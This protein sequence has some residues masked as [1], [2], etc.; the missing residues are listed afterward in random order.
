MDSTES[1][2]TVAVEL[3]PDAE[4]SAPSNLSALSDLNETET[5]ANDDSPGSDQDQAENDKTNDDSLGPGEEATSDSAD[6][7]QTSEVPVTEEDADEQTAEESEAV[8]QDVSE[9]EEA[10]ESSAVTEGCA[11]VS[12][13]SGTLPQAVEPP[14]EEVTGAEAGSSVAPKRQRKATAKVLEMEEVKMHPVVTPGP[15]KRGRKP[16][17]K[18]VPKTPE[19]AK[20]AEQSASPVVDSPATPRTKTRELPNGWSMKAVQRLTGASAGKYDIYYFSPENVKCRSRTDVTNYAV[21]YKADLDMELFEFSMSKLQQKGLVDTD[22]VVLARKKSSSVPQKAEKAQA[23]KVKPESGVKKAKGRLNNKSLFKNAKL[24]I[25]EGE[26]HVQAKSKGLFSKKK[27]VEVEDSPQKLQKLVIRMPFGSS[28]KG[29]MTKKESS[30]ICSY[31]APDEMAAEAE[32]VT[33]EIPMEDEQFTKLVGKA[34][35]R[36]GTSPIKGVPVKGQPGKKKKM[37]RPKKNANDSTENISQDTTANTSLLGSSLD[38]SAMDTTAD[39]SVVDPFAFPDDDDDVPEPSSM[40]MS[41]I[42][43]S[44]PVQKKK[45]G[46]KPKKR[47]RKPKQSPAAQVE[48]PSESNDAEEPATDEVIPAPEIVADEAAPMVVEEEQPAAPEETPMVSPPPV[49]AVDTPVV[50][51]K[52]GRPPKRKPETTPVPT[53]Q[54]T[55]ESTLQQTADSSQL[56]T[57]PAENESAEVTPKKSG[58]EE[59]SWE[60]YQKQLGGEKEEQKPDTSPHLDD[61]YDDRK[62]LP[63]ED[64]ENSISDFLALQS[65]IKAPKFLTADYMLSDAINMKSKYFKKSNT[66]NLAPLKLRRDDKWV[67]PRSPFCLVQESLF[68]DPWKLLIATIFL[69]KTTGRQAIPTLWKFLNRWPTPECVHSDDLEEMACLLFPIGLN[70]TRSKTIIRF[71]EEFLTKRWTYPIELHGIGKYG[72]DSYRIFCVNEWKQV[73]PTDHKLNDYHQWLSANQKQLGL[74]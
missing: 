62:S 53:E 37:G 57:P 28:S 26:G 34:T 45:V 33:E 55:P 21:K 47:G 17:G 56:E 49:V 61:E 3:V 8:T 18:A 13:E 50:K 39:T 60:D 11:D 51:K 23:L 48:A 36:K 59:L 41:S 2:S 68:H 54:E 74:S 1:K 29:K 64:T 63:D 73:E 58:V 14:E 72:N 9:Q 38:A 46:R 5:F 15:A 12:A 69:N 35:K 44:A 7:S 52:R 22:D 19:P 66:D 40:L 30:Q 25:A 10:A 67:P 32:M 31:F 4:L 71:S 65:Y 43:S 27:P 6:R 70:Y 16:K 42:K 20:Q 24:S